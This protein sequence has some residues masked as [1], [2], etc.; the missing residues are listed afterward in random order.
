M[1]SRNTSRD[2]NLPI[3]LLKPLL[4]VSGSEGG[5]LEDEREFG[6]N[7]HNEALQTLLNW[8]GRGKQQKHL[9]G[10][11]CQPGADHLEHPAQVDHAWVALEYAKRGMSGGG[12]KVVTLSS[13]CISMVFC[14]VLATLCGK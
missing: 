2:L 1:V 11:C 7:V 12:R 9:G 4:V 14:T 5:R 8:I 10:G 3:E 13:S 6:H